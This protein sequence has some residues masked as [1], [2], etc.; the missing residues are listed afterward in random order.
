MED[1]LESICSEAVDSL[2]P[3]TEMPLIPLGEL[4][5]FLFKKTVV[6]G[7]ESSYPSTTGRTW[8][9]WSVCVCFFKE[10]AG[11]GLKSAAATTWFPRQAVEGP[12]CVLARSEH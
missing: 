12:P 7:T 2:V 11:F 5:E 3:L 8:R 6:A 9:C 10:G 1:E 4:W